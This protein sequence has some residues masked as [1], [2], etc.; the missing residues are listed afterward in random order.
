MYNFY[1]LSAYEN[2][3]IN[4]LTLCIKIVNYVDPVFE[5]CGRFSTTDLRV[6]ILA[7]LHIK[8]RF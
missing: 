8:T 7:D 5:G 3:L 6:N 1:S 2:L 4:N